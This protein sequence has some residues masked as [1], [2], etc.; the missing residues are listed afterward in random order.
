MFYPG[1]AILIAYNL[2]F[3]LAKVV[4]YNVQLTSLI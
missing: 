4:L 1:V 2:G 3:T